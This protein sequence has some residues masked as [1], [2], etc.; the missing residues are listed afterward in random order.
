M[1]LFPG[2]KSG[3]TVASRHDARNSPLSHRRLKTDKSTSNAMYGRCLSMSLWIRS[4]PSDTLRSLAIADIN[5]AIEKD[6]LHVSSSEVE[7]STGSTSQRRLWCRNAG[8][9]LL[10]PQRSERAR[11]ISLA[12]LVGCKIFS[13]EPIT[14]VEMAKNMHPRPFYSVITPV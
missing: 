2:F 14:L 9:T 1:P 8:S 7:K 13:Y 4:G 10:S 6:R 12:T 3:I 11:P 5:S